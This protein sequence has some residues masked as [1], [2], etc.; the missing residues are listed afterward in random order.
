MRLATLAI[1]GSY[2]HQFADPYNYVQIAKSVLSGNGLSVDDRIYGSGLKAFYPPFYPLLLAGFGALFGFSGVAFVAMNGI[3]DALS[4]LIL[5]RYDIR[6]SAI[7]FLWPWN[8][9]GSVLAQKESLLCL[10]VVLSGDIAIRHQRDLTPLNAAKFGALSAL[11]ALTQP[12]LALFPAALAVIFFRENR[13][14]GRL[15]ACAGAASIAIFIPWWVRNW[16]LFDQFVPMTTSAGVSLAYVVNHGHFAPPNE[17]A[18]LPEPVRFA[19]VGA[20]ALEHLRAHPIRYVKAIEEQVMNAIFQE[21][22]AVWRIAP[23]SLSHWIPRFLTA[24]NVIL[25]G[26]A[27]LGRDKIGWRWLLASLICLWPAIWLEFG[28]RH[29]YFLLPSLAL[30]AS[31]ALTQAEDFFASKGMSV[32]RPTGPAVE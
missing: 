7:F 19:R 22:F 15:I 4:A 9:L 2:H 3:T 27:A 5:R 12:A 8:V 28:E 32:R 20:G 6:A 17:L 30:L 11:I 24:A 25:V 1:F 18:G 21:N 14:L 29:R 13:R 10:L 26:T 31:S 23:P 16:L